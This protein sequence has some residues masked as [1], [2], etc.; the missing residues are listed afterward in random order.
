METFESGRPAADVLMRS[1]RRFVEVTEAITEWQ[2]R[3]NLETAASRARFED[4]VVGAAAALEG[5]LPDGYRSWLLARCHALAGSE[6][7]LVARHNDLTM[8]NVLLDGQG[9]IGVIDWAEA[10]GAGLPLTDF[11][12]AVA[13][14]AAA[15]DGSR[16]RLA[17]VRSCFVPGGPRADA[18]AALQERLRDTLQ[19]RAGRGRAQ[20]PRVLAAP[21]AQRAT[22]G[23]GFRRAIPGDRP[24]GR[25]AR[26]GRDPVT[27]EP[28]RRLLF[29]LPF[30]PD[31]DGGHGAARMT[32][33]LLSSLAGAHDVAAIYLRASEEPPIDPA[34]N[35][36]LALVVEVERPSLHG[37]G[38]T[39][40]AV[41]RA[42]GLAAGRPLWA[43]DWAVPEF[44]ATVRE[45]A[46]DWRPDVVQGELHVMGQYLPAV[47]QPTV[48]VEHDPG[49]AAAAD[50]AAWERGLRRAG[51]RLDAFAWRRYE[52]GVLAAA[53]AVVAFTE[54]DRAALSALSPDA[55]VVRIA[56][57]I[58]LP[59][60]PSDPVGGEPPRVL[61]LGSFVH[62]PNIEAALRL[63]RAIMPAVRARV[64]G[65]ALEI[66]GDAPP[67]EVRALA[68]DG[69]VVTGRVADPRP[70]LD[71]AAVVAAPL[72]LGGGM[73]VKVLESLAAG[74]A[75]VATPRALAG[76]QLEPGT[77]ALVAESDVELSDALAGLL[78][79]PERRRRIG[80]A[81]REWATRHLGWDHAAA[82]YAALYTTLLAE[83][84][85]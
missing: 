51:R 41:R 55:R 85:E 11:F 75:I 56:P 60:Q 78:E 57:G 12:Y 14:A 45:V 19:A 29:L 40:R 48:L 77:H 26:P 74:K 9:T 76:L 30:P 8:W 13:D 64:P 1:P 73:R 7:P 72:R 28:R 54:E 84:G 36:R 42:L 21:R 83:G 53:D 22:V 31:P 71:G 62:P 44:A 63:A 68:G 10:D 5:K 49:A 39:R 20:L 18:V 37:A 66:V 33:Q 46:Q 79:D 32:G 47:A 3:W 17:A 24:V 52:R 2:G 43:T 27:V 15:C 50:L 69:V 82:A 61:F 25:S 16:D 58:S 35:D 80:A 23:E 81:A 59:S 70:H 65:T 34:L 67:G 6:P 38:Q 4:E